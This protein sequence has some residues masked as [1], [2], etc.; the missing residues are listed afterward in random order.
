M[1][2]CVGLRSAWSCNTSPFGIWRFYHG[3]VNTVGRPGNVVKHTALPVDSHKEQAEVIHLQS[4]LIFSKVCQTETFF[5]YLFVMFL[6]FS[7]LLDVWCDAF[8]SVTTLED[9]D[10]SCQTL[11]PNGAFFSKWQSSQINVPSGISFQRLDRKDE[12]GGELNQRA[13]NDGR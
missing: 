11:N 8:K 13:S 10:I 12:R 7:T 5:M 9:V 2:V 6:W 3:E 4:K 1:E